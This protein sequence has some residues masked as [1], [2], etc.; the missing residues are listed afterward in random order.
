[1]RVRSD[2]CSPLVL[3]AAEGVVR[4]SGQAARRLA[5]FEPGQRLREGSVLGR[6]DENAVDHGIRSTAQCVSARQAADESV[7][8]E[9]R[10]TSRSRVHALGP[11]LPYRPV[12]GRVASTAVGALEVIDIDGRERHRPRSDRPWSGPIPLGRP[13]AARICAGQGVHSRRVDLLH[14]L[15]TSDCR[16]FESRDRLRR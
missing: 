10:I 4:P 16:A 12:A 9:R 13:R 1:M 8:P 14:H 7:M 5:R 11:L 6:S 2:G 15:D 3:L